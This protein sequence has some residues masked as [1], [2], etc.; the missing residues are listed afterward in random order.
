MH[1]PTFVIACALAAAACSKPEEKPAQMADTTAAPAAAPAPAPAPQHQAIVTV[2]YKWPKSPAAFEKYYPTHIKIVGDG[3]AEIGFTKAELTK[4][5]TSIDGKKPAFYR[6]AELYFPSLD[7]AKKG[8]ATDAFKKVGDD[9]GKF[10]TG[11]LLGM[12]AVETGDKSDTPCPALVTV[13]YHQP[14]DAAAFESYYPTHLKIVGDGHAEIGFVRADLT[15]FDS[16]L[17]GST[18]AAEYRQAE[19]CFPSM[20]A[21]KKGT[22]TPAFKKVGDDFPNFASGG[23]A[24]LIGEQK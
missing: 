14:K 20:D 6:Q 15:K 22:A 18:P 17:D 3:Q 23:L 19:L 10:A 11:G 16:N 8:I 7:A 5:T 9:L 12:V 2:I 24:G 4:F 13:I 1:R 21:L